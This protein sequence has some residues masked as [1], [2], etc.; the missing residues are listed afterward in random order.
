MHYEDKKNNFSNG[1]MLI[2][3]PVNKALRHLHKFGEYSEAI[4]NRY[5]YFGN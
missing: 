4:N 2:G 5:F 3:N 1:K